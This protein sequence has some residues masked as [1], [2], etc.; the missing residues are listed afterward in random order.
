M[1]DDLIESDY[2]ERKA[3]QGTRSLKAMGVDSMD[4]NFPA[5]SAEEMLDAMRAFHRDIASKV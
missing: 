5:S 4:F 3:T 1:A 2:E